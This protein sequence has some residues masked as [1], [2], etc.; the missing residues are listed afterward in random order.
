MASEWWE[1][2]K[3]LFKTDTQIEQER[4][5]KIDEVLNAEKEVANKLAELEKQYNATLVK[6]EM[7]DADELF[8]QTQ[9]REEIEYNPQSDEDI[10]AIAQR[11]IGANKT[12]SKNSIESQYEKAVASLNENKQ[13][14]KE[15]LNDSYENLS[16]LYAELKEKANND[17]LRRG[18]ARSSVATN[19]ID[20][21]D[22]EHLSSAGEVE[23]TYLKTLAN[24]DDSLASLAKDRE[25]ALGELDLKSATELDKK[26]DELKKEREEKIK[27][28]AEY[29][30]QVRKDNDKAEQARQENIEKYKAEWEEKQ[31]LAEEERI[32]YENK[33]GYSGEKQRNYS[34]RYNLAYDFYSSLSPDIAVDA[35]KASPNM[36]YYLG[37]Y[38]DKLL[39]SLRSKAYSW[40][41]K[42]YY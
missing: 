3:N 13:S 14:A 9:K 34:E 1:E 18:M 12:A 25:S 31:K 17:S 10:V 5:Q 26:I 21:L 6:E 15:N 22:Q 36:K 40:S 42:T 28:Y 27:E 23:K 8:P 4:Q 39:S 32:A 11:E 33:Y 35:L 24:I 19:R 37:N 38:Y 30:A 2:F 29:N 41:N 7:P 20:A 16:K